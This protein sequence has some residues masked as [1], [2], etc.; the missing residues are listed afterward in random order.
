MINKLFTKATLIRTLSSVL[1]LAVALFTLIMGG[2]ILFVTMFVVSL[3]GQFE[4]YRVISR[5]K[6]LVGIL[7][8]MACIGYYLL[9]L[10]EMQEFAMLLMIVFLMVIMAAYV[11]TFPGYKAGE[12]CYIFFGF[13]YVAVMMSYVYQ[14]RE[15]PNGICLV[16]LVFLSSWIC[17]TCA[18]LV[19]VTIGKHKLA[20]KLSPN[21]SIEGSVGGIVGAALLGALYGFVF[22]GYLSEAFLNPL[23]GCAIV[24]G[25]GAVISQIGDLAASGIK[26]NYSVKDYGHLIPGHGGIM[27]RFDSVIFV[28]PAIY[29]LTIFVR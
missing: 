18:Y 22:R 20:P 9:L 14:I 29:F 28:A 5:Q 2:N 25:I 26:R 10:L 17:D 12:I 19:G 3:I 4:L 8:Y 11:F 13:F 16:F 24:C 21:K 7:G 1:L 27:D 6:S 15:L 23:V